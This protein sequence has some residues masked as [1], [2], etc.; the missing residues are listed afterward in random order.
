MK[1]V[2]KEKI[3]ADLHERLTR[4][5]AVFVTDFRGLNVVTLERLRRE[6]RKQGDEY[7]VV[8]NTLFQRAAQDTP[9]TALKDL[10]VGPSGIAISYQ[11]PV[12]A[13][14]VLADFAKERE[15]FVLKGGM[16]EGKTLPSEAVRQLAK[17]PPREVLLGQLLSSLV[18]VPTGLVSALAGILQKFLGT[19][20][21]IE[22]KKAET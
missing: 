20:K 16:L 21:A 12:A 4:A 14:K 11:D 7:Q 18:A 17:M 10:F 3:V 2:K 9:M 15:S 1:R 5:Q 22:E 13:A 8:K 6:L 19:L